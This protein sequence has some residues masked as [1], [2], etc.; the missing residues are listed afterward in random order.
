[1][2]HPD[3]TAGFTLIEVLVALA[4]AALGLAALF[5]ATGSGLESG[6]AAHRTLQA[7]GLA[8]SQLAQVGKALALKKGDYS[9]ESNGLRWR[10][11]MDAPV[12]HV[13]PGH[14]G[15]GH[16]GSGVALGLY[17]VTV[18]VGWRAGAQQKTFSLYSERLG[19]P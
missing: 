2:P 17:P 14:A 7:T 11:H 6:V 4:I 9:G 12:F 19:P 8:Q 16:A 10:V 18:T 15:P 13:G 3:R 1:M 5:A